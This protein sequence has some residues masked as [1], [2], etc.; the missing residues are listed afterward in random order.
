MLPKEI[1]LSNITSVENLP[2]DTAMNVELV[3]NFYLL[4]GI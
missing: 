4:M 1:V 3:P 2:P